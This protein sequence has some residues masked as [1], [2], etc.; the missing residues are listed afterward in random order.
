VTNTG[1]YSGSNT[2]CVIDGT[3][4]TLVKNVTVGKQPYGVA[5]NPNT[6]KV[7]VTNS[8]SDTVSVISQVS[9]NRTPPSSN[10]RA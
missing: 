10:S 3:T 5:V 9:L 6:N 7:Y 8:G 2:V 4:D 1:Y